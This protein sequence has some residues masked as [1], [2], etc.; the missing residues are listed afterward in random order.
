MGA[1]CLRL[2][3]VHFSPTLAG[4][5]S[6]LDV[7]HLVFMLFSLPFSFWL[8]SLHSVKAPYSRSKPGGVVYRTVCAHR[9]LGTVYTRSASNQPAS[10]PDSGVL[11][12]QCLLLVDH[13]LRF[14]NPPAQTRETAAARCQQLEFLKSTE[15]HPL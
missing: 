13:L 2:Q 1:V 5:R 4:L 9:T 15:F 12:L 8:W 10:Q 14:V 3:H 6:D 7:A 11:C